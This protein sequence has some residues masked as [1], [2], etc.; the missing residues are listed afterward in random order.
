MRE[1]DV[2]LTV[3]VELLLE[4][5][6]TLERSIGVTLSVADQ[7]TAEPAEENNGM[8]LTLNKMSL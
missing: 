1:S 8:L 7:L 5:G 2:E 6:E 3:G 4:E